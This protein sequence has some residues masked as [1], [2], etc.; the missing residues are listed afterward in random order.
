MNLIEK[1]NRMVSE[2]SD[3]GCSENAAFVNRILSVNAPAGE[4]FRF[5]F[6]AE[7]EK[8]ARFLPAASSEEG[9]TE[10]EKESVF[11]AFLYAKK[12]A[13]FSYLSQHS[14]YKTITPAKWY[15]CFDVYIENH[16]SMADVLLKKA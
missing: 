8:A 1:L 6:H 3:V 13:A 16:P 11:K 5:N 4:P 15:A 10:T 2:S 14:A 7:I 12:A 9:L